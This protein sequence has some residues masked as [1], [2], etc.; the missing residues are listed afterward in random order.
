MSG[1]QGGEKGPATEPGRL[2]RELGGNS[3]LPLLSSPVESG[4]G[5]H[6][7]FQRLLMGHVRGELR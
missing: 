3:L 6:P 2:A 5:W 4:Q 7:V 1:G